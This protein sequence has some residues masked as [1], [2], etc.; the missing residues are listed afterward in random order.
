MLVYGIFVTAAG[1]GEIIL[2]FPKTL[3]GSAADV[4]D[5]L[6]WGIFLCVFWVAFAERAV[7]DAAFWRRFV[8]ALI[9][10]DL[11]AIVF[12][13]FNQPIAL[14][15]GLLEIGFSVVLSVPLYITGWWYAFAFMSTS[16]RPGIDGQ[17]KR[18]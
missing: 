10:A 6:A 5:V 7:G 17:V 3:R 16:D 2:S 15:D 1:V 18:R 4:I 12:L 14:V 8:P 9:V 11:C 13:T